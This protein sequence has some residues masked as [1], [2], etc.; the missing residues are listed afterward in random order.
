MLS[1]TDAAAAFTGQITVKCTA[2]IDGKPVVR[3]ARPATIT[4]AVAPNNNTPTI[5]RLDQGLFF[6]VK[7]DKAL[8]RL[9]ADLAN[10]KVKSKDKD[11]KETDAKLESPIFLKPGDKITL[12]VLVVWQGAEA[13]TNPV[14]ITMEPTQANMQ[15]AAIGT[16][17]GGGNA[18]AGMMAKEK[19][20][21]A[22]VLDVR[23][24]ALPGTYAVVL[25][26]DTLIQV[27]RDPA[28]KDAKTPAN[29]QGYTQPIEIT[30]LP[31][32]L[33][34]FTATLPAN[35]VIVAGK[36]AEMVVKVERTADYTGEFKVSLA[37]PKDF[38][39]VTVKDAVILAGQD[40]VKL[41][42][43]VAADAKVGGVTNVVVTATGTV[44]G[45]FPI[46]GEAKSNFTIA[47][48]PK[49]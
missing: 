41:T 43:E 46:A 2:T 14:N 22:I 45:K 12:P 47:A 16:T 21:A 7:P 42:L 37:L 9:N 19:N 34:K 33:G 44:H 5:S 1:A 17:G 6:A 40:E 49:K 28:K 38:K 36:S 23:P 15:N 18:P 32:S 27:A 31:L 35:G 8:F 10:A 25:K 48:P 30:V 29:V 4:W 39:G 26:G 24:A 3:T 13:R 11:G 20:D